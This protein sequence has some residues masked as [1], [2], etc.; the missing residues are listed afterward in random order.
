MKAYIVTKE[1]FPNGMAATN[2]IKC[3]ARAIH[4]GGMDCEVLICGSTEL[5]REKV[6]NPEAKGYYEGVPYKYIGGSSTD[7]HIN[8]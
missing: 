6:K 8:H 1:P 5:V 7:F 2:R 4:D 3:Y